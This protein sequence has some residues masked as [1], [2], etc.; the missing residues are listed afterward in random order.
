ML[1]PQM[2]ARI[3]GAAMDKTFW[4]LAITVMVCGVCCQQPSAMVSATTYLPGTSGTNRA[5][6]LIRAPHSVAGRL[7]M[8]VMFVS[9]KLDLQGFSMSIQYA[10]ALG[11]HMAPGTIG[12]GVGVGGMR[13]TGG[14]GQSRPRYVMSAVRPKHEGIEGYLRGIV[15]VGNELYAAFAK[16]GRVWSA[17]MRWAN[18]VAPQAVGEAPF[19]VHEQATVTGKGASSTSR[20]PSLTVS[21]TT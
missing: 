21:L 14:V 16:D 10:T 7:L 20:H 2:V 3:S 17:I 12:G 9:A 6:S 4:H 15:T 5:V 19:R 11:L 18:G 1:F 13:L 8:Y